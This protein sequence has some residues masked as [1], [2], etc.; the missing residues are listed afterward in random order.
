VVATLLVSYKTDTTTE[1]QGETTI[2]TGAISGTEAPLAIIPPNTTRTE[3]PKYGGTITIATTT[4]PT[5]FDDGFSLMVHVSTY[6]L[7]LTN[8]ELLQGDWT[9]GPAGTGEATYTMGG[10]NSMS[11]KTGALADSWEIPYKGKIIFHICEGVHWQ[12]KPPTN[13]REVTIDDIVF[14]LTRD[15][16]GKGGYVNLTYPNWSANGTITGDEAARTVTVEAPPEEWIN[17]IV[18]VPNYFSI[19]PRDALEL[20]GNMNDWKHSLGS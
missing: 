16:K 9:K 13:G 7:N 2:V 20:W 17:L 11:L 10:V 4:D 1:E 19:F 8:D 6:T 14:T 3:K 12:N 5:A 15:I 18:M